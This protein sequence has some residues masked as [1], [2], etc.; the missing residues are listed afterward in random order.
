MDTKT[1]I[2][3]IAKELSSKVYAQEI[4]SNLGKLES[5]IG[6][7]LTGAWIG[8]GGYPAN[9]EISFKDDRDLD[10]VNSI[11]KKLGANTWKRIPYTTHAFL[12]KGIN[13]PEVY[14]D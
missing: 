4:K 10:T 9:M 7:K 6:Q 12:F 1:E 5:F 14:K 2:I 13:N 8:V 11:A 3:R